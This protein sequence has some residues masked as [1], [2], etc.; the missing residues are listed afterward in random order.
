MLMRNGEHDDRIKA[1]GVVQRVRKSI[2]QI[3]MEAINDRMSRRRFANRRQRAFDLALE[4]CGRALAPLEVPGKR[5]AR[6]ALRAQVE[7]DSQGHGSISTREDALTRFGPRDRL[8]LAALDL[9]EST[10]G[11]LDPRPLNVFGGLPD[12]VQKSQGKLGPVLLGE[13]EGFVQELQRVRHHRWQSGTCP[14]IPHRSTAAGRLMRS[15]LHP[16]RPQQHLSHAISTTY[17]PRTWD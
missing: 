9:A 1:D 13:L 6:F 7:L 5:F 2:E 11:F 3:P 12:A 14:A 17:A 16:S 4:R 10:L 15:L 8:N